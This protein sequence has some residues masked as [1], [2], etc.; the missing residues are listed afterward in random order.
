[1]DVLWHE[2]TP[3]TDHEV[4]PHASK[5][6][7]CVQPAEPVLEAL[8]DDGAGVVQVWRQRKVRAC[9]LSHPFM[10]GE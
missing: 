2:F 7:V 8:A 4:E 3:I 5:G 9:N 1:M 6:H 10:L